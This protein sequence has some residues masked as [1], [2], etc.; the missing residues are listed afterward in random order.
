MVANY[1]LTNKIRRV[2]LKRVQSSHEKERRYVND[3]LFLVMTHKPPYATGPWAFRLQLE[4]RWRFPC[5]DVITC[6]RKWRSLVIG[7]ERS[8]NAEGKLESVTWWLVV[9]IW[10]VLFSMLD[11]RR[12]LIRRLFVCA[13]VGSRVT[14]LLGENNNL[15]LIFRNREGKA[16][17]PS[18]CVLL[19]LHNTCIMLR[20]FP[21][22]YALI[23]QENSS[24]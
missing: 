19:H 1:T 8:G 9:Y 4:S 23:P 5:C 2:N 15:V 6:F 7:R 14:I 17:L 12:C 11:K 21:P 18:F 3:D 16:I 22:F 20:D 10:I 13:L 24:M